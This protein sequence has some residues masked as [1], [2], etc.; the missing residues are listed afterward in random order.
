VRSQS[1]G[2]R[3]KTEEARHGTGSR[4]KLPHRSLSTHARAAQRLNLPFPTRAFFRPVDRLLL[5]ACFLGLPPPLAPRGIFIPPRSPA[6]SPRQRFPA[7]RIYVD[8]KSCQVRVHRHTHAAW[9]T[10][11]PHPTSTAVVFHILASRVL[12]SRAKLS[13]RWRCASAPP[14]RPSSPGPAAPGGGWPRRRWPLRGGERRAA[15][16]RWCWRARR[17]RRRRGQGGGRGAG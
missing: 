11:P 17:P 8:R 7:E 2:R 14:R 16:E 6:H 9:L 12:C 13:K 3:G 4:P 5:L 10:F 15:G 1:G